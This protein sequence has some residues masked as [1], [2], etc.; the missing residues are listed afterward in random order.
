MKKGILGICLTLVLC[1]GL[2]PTTALAASGDTYLA[3]G[4]SITTGY[5]PNN[6]I[7]SSPFANQVAAAQGYTL[8]NEAADGETSE[9]LKN[10][11]TGN[12][13]NVSD[14]ALIS[15]TIGGNDLMDALYGYLVEQYN[16]AKD[17]DITLERLKAALSDLSQEE[18]IGRAHV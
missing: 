3:L 18:K 8:V 13:I 14:A 9:T 17:P 6:T 7:V 12:I 11:L 10:K 16:A 15:I 2:L 4:D 1:L 5:A